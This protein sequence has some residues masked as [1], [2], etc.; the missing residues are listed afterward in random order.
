MRQNRRR[1]SNRFS[2]SQKENK[3]AEGKIERLRGE[4]EAR[5]EGW[6]HQGAQAERENRLRAAENASERVY[7]RDPVKESQRQFGRLLKRY[8]A[9]MD[10][11]RADYMICTDMAKQG[12]SAEQLVPLVLSSGSRFAAAP[13]STQPLPKC[14]P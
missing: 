5:A 13:S 9:D 1:A 6:E 3:A 7:G 4:F 12:Y 8:G 10:V 2:L 11:S 14:Q